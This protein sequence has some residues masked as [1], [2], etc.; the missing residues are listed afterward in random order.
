M[1]EI[2]TLGDW[3]FD[4]GTIVDSDGWPIADI[5]EQAGTE[6]ANGLLIAAAPDLLAALEGLM[7]NIREGG[8][9]STRPALDAIAKARGMT[10][11]RLV[12]QM[13]DPETVLDTALGLTN[14]AAE[15]CDGFCDHD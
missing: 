5:C 2:P 10:I 8:Y 6:D 7:A 15:R 13:E 1:S 11:E 12:R 14:L 4:G 3:H 9:I